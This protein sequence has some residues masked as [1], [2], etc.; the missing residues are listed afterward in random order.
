[1]IFCKVVLKQPL[2]WKALYKYIHTNWLD[3]YYYF[4]SCMKSDLK[5]C[6]CS[7]LAQV[8]L[9]N[10]KRKTRRIEWQYVSNTHLDRFSLH[11][12]IVHAW[13]HD[14]QLMTSWHYSPSSRPA[15]VWSQSSGQVAARTRSRVW[16]TP[17]CSVRED[18]LSNKRGHD[19]CGCW[20]ER[21]TW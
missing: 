13:H 7:R 19:L 17:F 2:L 20:T 15:L 8:G 6:S 9:S 3:Y 16:L 4:C 14:H 11:Y 10:S 21:M 18:C 5:Q 1:M 12:R